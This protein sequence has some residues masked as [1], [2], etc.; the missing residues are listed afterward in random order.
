MKDSRT[1]AERRIESATGT[2]QAVAFV[3]LRY[4]LVLV[5]GWIAAMKVTEYEPKASNHSLPTVL[6]L[7]GDTAYGQFGSSPLSLEASRSSSQ[8]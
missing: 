3:L 1:D 6:S 7:A 5:I 2:I 8:R 4:G